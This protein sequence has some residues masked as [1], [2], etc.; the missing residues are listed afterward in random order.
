MKLLRLLP[1]FQE[2]Y[3][4]LETFA[5]RETWSRK[6]IESYQIERLNRLWQHATT[7]VDHYRELRANKKLP[8]SFRSIA[9]FQTTV[10]LLPKRAVRQNPKAFVS[11]RLDRGHWHRTGGSTGTPM[12][13]YW[14]DEAHQEV[15]RARYRLYSM[16]GI[17]PLDRTAFLWGHQHVFSRS[18]RGHLGRVQQ[19]LTDR[20]RG[21]LRLSA[22][23]LGKKDVQRY[24]RRMSS[25][26]PTMLYGFSR[27]IYMLALEAQQSNWQSDSLRLVT[28]TSE[29]A[30]KAMI[31]AVERGF[32]VP[33]IVE[34]GASECHV[35][36]GEWTDRTLRV[37]EDL[38]IVETLPRADHR[39][40]LVITV[41]G[42]LSTPLIRYQIGDVTD[43]P[44]R[45]PANG[46]AILR[47]VAGRNDD[48]LVTR[49]GRVIHPSLVDAVFE[50][51]VDP[52]R[53]YRVHQ[54]ADGSLVAT[55]ELHD[56][57]EKFQ[58]QH[59][60]QRLAHLI[61][62]FPVRVNVVDRIVLTAAGKHR[63]VTSD[64]TSEPRSLNSPALV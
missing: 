43:S 41:L 36:A 38:V 55:L 24:L 59:Y 37:R 60:E 58:S 35:I 47:N 7:H 54:H 64:F 20:L 34:Y 33:A 22:Y 9:E 31:T 30:S 50:E 14:N 3:R 42:N 15:L 32:G 13:F 48:L 52:I 16:W 1:R 61:E 28:L 62:G 57:N 18:V 12:S 27:A 21:R 49:S 23:H 26:R 29:A 40:D 17:D 11:E 2:A 6:Q 53:R 51:A 63:T 8:D 44:L 4:S 56:S 39:F 19:H 46:F 45:Y 25:F 10:P 5:E